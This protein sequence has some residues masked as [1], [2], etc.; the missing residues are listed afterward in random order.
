MVAA[1]TIC[2]FLLYCAAIPVKFALYV[3]LNGRAGF[4]AGLSV[5]EGRYALRSAGARARGEKKPL[6]WRGNA[7]KL[8]I[9]CVLPAAWRALCYLARRVHLD[10]LR[11]EGRLSLSDAAH[12]ALAYGCLRGAAGALAPVMDPRSLRFDLQPDFSA[13]PGCAGFSCIV[14]LRLGHIIAAAL[15]G[16]WYYLARRI[17]HGKASD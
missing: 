15:I 4:G 8:Q 10:Q 2:L 17:A 5:F 6:A 13:G 14:S 1:A 9:R 12:T 16:A 11:L 7:P 3:H